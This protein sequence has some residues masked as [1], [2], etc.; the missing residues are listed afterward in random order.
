MYR[1]VA[2]MR[3]SAGGRGSFD[4]ACTGAAANDDAVI[5]IAIAIALAFILSPLCLEYRA[6]DLPLVKASTWLVL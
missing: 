3:H 2:G 4:E 5:A 1:A 6:N